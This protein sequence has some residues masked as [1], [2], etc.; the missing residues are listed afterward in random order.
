MATFTLKSEQFLNVTLKEAWG[1]FSSPTNLSLITPSFMKFQMR[2][3]VE[4]EIYDQLRI[5]YYVRPVFGVKLKWRTEILD[6]KPPYF[7]KDIQLKGPFKKW[8][9]SHYFK[10]V[11]GKVLMTD[12]VVYELPLGWIGN[13]VHSLTVRRRVKKIFEY[14]REILESMFNKS[15]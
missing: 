10:E 4:G 12:V 13:M 3:T 15:K 1:F 7:F 9:H 11:D 5:D 2:T 8:E 14:R 6:V